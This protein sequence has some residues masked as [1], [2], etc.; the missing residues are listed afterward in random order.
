MPVITN[1]P[2]IN[3]P[4]TMVRAASS[5]SFILLRKFRLRLLD[6]FSLV[7]SS[8]GPTVIGKSSLGS[9][10][11][12]LDGTR[13]NIDSRLILVMRLGGRCGGWRSP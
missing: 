4:M 10:W 5:H 11:N 7:L 12:W 6:R 13:C 9:A 8:G 2:A 3:P 1:T